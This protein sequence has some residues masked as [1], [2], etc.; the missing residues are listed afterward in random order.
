M[1]HKDLLK[2]VA[3]ITLVVSAVL[4]GFEIVRD[5]VVG[6]YQIRDQV[7]IFLLPFLLAII[8]FYILNPLVE[9]IESYRVPRIATILGVYGISITL[10]VLVGISLVNAIFIEIQEFAREIP[11]FTREFRQFIDETEFILYELPP[12]ITDAINEAIIEYQVNFQDILGTI[13]DFQGIIGTGASILAYVFSLIAL[14]IILF[15]FLKDTEIL[16]SNM[17]L[18]VPPKYRGKVTEIMKDVSITFGNYIR[19]QLVVCL[20]IGILTYIGLAF[21]GVEFALVLG[22]IAGITNIIPYF[23]PFIGAVPSV[24]IAL[25]EEPLLALKVVIWILIVQQIESQL[26][27]PQ[28]LGRNLKLHPLAVVTSLIAG[29]HFFGFLGLI[30]AVPVVAIVRVIIRHLFWDYFLQDEEQ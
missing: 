12:P 17:I 20:F 26:V 4:F 9:F 27:A 25:L 6:V 16:R 22:I 2:L 21:L 1:E 5:F 23:G 10:L 13:L 29:G 8:L 28:I 19:G 3:W 30:L 18:V 11:Y 15:Y 24:I 7:F 14:P